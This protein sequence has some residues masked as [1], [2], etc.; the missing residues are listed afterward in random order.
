MLPELYKKTTLNKL[1][2]KEII[3]K[4]RLFDEIC[5]SKQKP[6]TNIKRQNGRNTTKPKLRTLLNYRG[7]HRVIGY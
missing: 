1:D 3:I 6:E 4:I 5:N 2:G 7:F